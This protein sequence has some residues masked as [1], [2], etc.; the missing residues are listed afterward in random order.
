MESSLVISAPS[1]ILLYCRHAGDYLVM[2]EPEDQANLVN[3]IVIDH[4]V[5]VINA[6]RFIAFHGRVPLAICESS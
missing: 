4:E 3:V 2:A 6:D 1:I 5:E